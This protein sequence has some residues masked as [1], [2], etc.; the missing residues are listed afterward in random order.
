MTVERYFLGYDLRACAKDYV[1]TEWLATRR[2]TY[3]LKHDIRWPLSVDTA[4]WPS[5]FHFTSRRGD[6]RPVE[7]VEVEPTNNEQLVLRLWA[8]F[9]AMEATFREKA[10]GQTCFVRVAIE[11]W[12]DRRD[13]AETPEW[14]LIAETLSRHGEPPRGWTSVGYD[15]ADTDFVSGLMNCGY[16]ENERTELSASTRALNEFGLFSDLERAAEFRSISEKRVPEH[17]PFFVYR[18]LVDLNGGT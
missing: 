18:L 2:L 13:A 6:Y 17:A 8:D 16:M 5:L 7:T 1:S 12:D 11:L 9:A 14:Q 10:K 3:L 15:I 4:V